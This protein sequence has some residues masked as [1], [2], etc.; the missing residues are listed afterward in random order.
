[1]LGSVSPLTVDK[2]ED[3]HLVA[4]DVVV[5]TGIV[6]SIHAVHWQHA[7]RSDGDA[8]ELFPVPDSGVATAVSSANGWTP[9]REHL[10]FVGYV[11]GLTEV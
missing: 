9:D 1:M 4:D 10:Q 7:P 6:T 5:T 2:V 8:R 11:V 3:H